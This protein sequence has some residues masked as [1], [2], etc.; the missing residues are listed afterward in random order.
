MCVYVCVNVCVWCVYVCACV[1]M[2]VCMCVYV[3]MC[4]C[5]CVCMCAC[6]CVG[7]PYPVPFLVP[8]HQI[9]DVL[10][11][12]IPLLDVAQVDKFETKHDN[13][14]S[15]H[16]SMVA[17]KVCV[18]VHVCMCVCV[19]VCMCACVYVC[20][21]ACVYVCTGV[22]VCV[23]VCVHVV[24]H[25]WCC[26]GPALVQYWSSAGPVL[27]QYWSSVAITSRSCVLIF[28]P[29]R[30][31]ILFLL[32]LDQ[33]KETKCTHF[34]VLLLRKPSYYGDLSAGESTAWCPP[35]PPNV[36]FN[37]T[38]L[39]SLTQHLGHGDDSDNPSD[40]TPEPPLSCLFPSGTPPSQKTIAQEKVKEKSWE[41]HFTNNGRLAART[42]LCNSCITLHIS[43]YSCV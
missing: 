25:V 30:A 23:Q 11:C 5:I 15:I 41:I 8:I 28:S 2:C 38:H 13:K 10:W 26:P 32:H 6:V 37:H 3:W 24:S 42:S 22:C 33:R 19:H 1:C 7:N 35:L 20:M 39:S 4:V 17:S 36:T 14:H 34:C 16:I 21:C 29:N 18:C 40:H 31:W 12:V 43:A 9:T 27:V